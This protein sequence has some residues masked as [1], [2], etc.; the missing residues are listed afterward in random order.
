MK[1][2]V[3]DEGPDVFAEHVRKVRTAAE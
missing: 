3:L 1:Q 2:N